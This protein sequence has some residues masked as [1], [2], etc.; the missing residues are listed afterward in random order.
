MFQKLV[1]TGFNLMLI[2]VSLKKDSNSKS[3]VVEYLNKNGVKFRKTIEGIMGELF[4][5]QFR[6]DTC[7]VFLNNLIFGSI[8][9]KSLNF[10]SFP[11]S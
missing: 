4:F 3:M 6:M 8:L 2:P 9:S 5:C 7:C 10:N 11:N 1:R